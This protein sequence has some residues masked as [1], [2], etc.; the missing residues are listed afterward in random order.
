MKWATLSDFALPFYLTHLLSHSFHFFPH[1]KLVD[2]LRVPHK[3]SMDS[4][5]ETYLHTR[6]DWLANYSARYWT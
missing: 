2:N 3:E 1:L 6:Y 4:F 5:D